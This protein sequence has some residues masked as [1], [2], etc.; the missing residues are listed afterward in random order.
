MFVSLGAEF[1]WLGIYGRRVARYFGVDM[2]GLVRR[3]GGGHVRAGVVS[4]G[5]SSAPLGWW[6][7]LC[8]VSSVMP[9]E[10]GRRWVGE[11]ESFVF[12]A[13]GDRRVLRGLLWS[14]PETAAVMWWGELSRM[15]RLALPGRCAARRGRDSWP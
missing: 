13:P 1:L 2:T 10:A 3:R 6:R 9:R 4:A 5:C 7:V 8:V 15:A 11:A 14:A 12:E